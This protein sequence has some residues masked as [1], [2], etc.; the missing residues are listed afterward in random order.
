MEKSMSA[1]SSKSSHL[2]F[3]KAC[4]ADG[5]RCDR[6]GEIRP[7]IAA[8]LRSPRAALV[9]TIVDAEEKPAEPDELKV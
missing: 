6:R 3:A 7:A 2:A 4:G 5:L 8:A 9:E 1:I